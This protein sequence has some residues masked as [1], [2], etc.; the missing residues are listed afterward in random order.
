MPGI[1][2]IVQ[3]DAVAGRT[4]DSAFVVDCASLDRIGDVRKNLDGLKVVNL[5]HHRSNTRFGNL[6]YVEPDTCASGM[7]VYHLNERLGLGLSKAKATN[8][9][10]GIITDTGNFRYSNTTPEVL[11]VGSRLIETGIDSARIASLLFATKPIAAL[12]LLGEALEALTAELDGRVGLI[13][14]DREVFARTGAGQSDVEGIVNYA[15]QIAGTDAGVLMREV[16]NGEVK[17]SFRAEGNVDVDRVA[18]CFGGGGHR[19]AAG[20]RLPG[21]LDAAVSRVL[22]ELERALSEPGGS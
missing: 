16:E 22:A 5:D 2:R 6:N 13:V 21:P 18:R 14:L 12:K 4:F 7:I 11:R 20:A 19:N 8:I 3:P 1:E 17:V 9:Y 15:K 10:V